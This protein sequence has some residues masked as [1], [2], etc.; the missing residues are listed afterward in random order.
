M[1]YHAKF[2]FKV[3]I[4]GPVRWINKLK[5]LTIKPDNLSLI[6]GTYTGEEET[7]HMSHGWQMRTHTLNKKLE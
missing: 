6:P 3:L 2:S 5:P 1:Y 4:S 7:L